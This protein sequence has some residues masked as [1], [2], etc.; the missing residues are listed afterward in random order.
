[1]VIDRRDNDEMATSRAGIP[2]DVSPAARLNAPVSEPLALLTASLAAGAELSQAEIEAAVEALVDE[3]APDTAKAAFLRALRAKGETAGDL[4]GF[5]RAL[6]RRAVDPG[7][8]PG[9]APGPLLDV[10]GTG[11]DR[12]EMFNVSTTA[13][14]VLAA[15]GAA[16]VK[17]GNRAITSRSGGAD[18]LEALG[19]RIDLPPAALRRGVEE[20][21]IGFLFAPNYHPAFRSIAPVRRAL[22]A[23]G[24]STIF[25]LL[26]P[27]L[28]PARPEHQLV[29]VFA[30]AWTAPFAEVFGKLGRRRA[31]AVHG[32]GGM[33][34]LSLAGA[35]PVSRW[36]G[37]AVSHGTIS[38]GDA[39]LPA[40]ASLDA[41]RGGDAAE[42]AR[43]LVRIL[44]GEEAGAR[45][46]VVLLNAAAGFVVAGLASDLPGGVERARQAISSGAAWRKLEAMR[47]FQ[48]S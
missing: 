14:F 41:L 21:G 44:A 40:L 5:T 4:A 20:A 3:R 31:W 33:D 39:G 48:R 36:E 13:S 18:V 23:E 25:N 34:E 6:L 11:G 32:A 22:A 45:R 12:R 9:R 29:G 17:H 10:C 38:P 46:D 24:T 30:A 2:V 26:G 7:I 43:L 35:S 42:N 28:N 47:S 16:V 8:D 37:G 27:L 15:G 19:V 1:M